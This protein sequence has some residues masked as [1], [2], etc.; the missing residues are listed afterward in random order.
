MINIVSG[1]R[2]QIKQLKD[3]LKGLN[4]KKHKP[5]DIK[6]LMDDL[7]ALE[8]RYEQEK[9]KRLEKQKLK[10]TQNEKAFEEAEKTVETGKESPKQEDVV[11][12]SDVKVEDGTVV[13]PKKEFVEEHEKLV[14]ELEPMV[15]EHKEQGKELEEVK[16]EAA[17]TC[18]LC[19]DKQ[20]PNYADYQAHRE[21]EH[22]HP[23]EYTPMDPAKKKDIVQRVEKSPEMAPHIISKFN[24]DD[25]V[26][27]KQCRP[28]SKTITWEVVNN[29]AKK[30]SDKEQ[31]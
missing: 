29:N 11:K 7:E 18:A 22:G 26:S 4:T 13:M 24:I 17:P 23:K 30:S 20:F 12:E 16:K 27:I 15:E 19:G 5:S 25:V 21:K 1:I 31:K 3:R 6:S 10:E 2:S 28:Y 9:A 8:K 14:K